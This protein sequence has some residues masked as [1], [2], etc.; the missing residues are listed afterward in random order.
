MRP[1]IQDQLAKAVGTSSGNFID[2]LFDAS[3]EPDTLGSILSESTGWIEG[4]DE[5]TRTLCLAAR[6]P[7]TPK[8]IAER[9]ING[10]EPL[11]WVHLHS[12][13][14]TGKIPEEARSDMSTLLLTCDIAS[15]YTTSSDVAP[16]AVAFAATHAGEL[17]QEIVEKVRRE[18][19]QL[20]K[21]TNSLADRPRAMKLGEMI[22][23]AALYLYRGAATS[24]NP[25][26]L[27]G[28]LWL[29]LVQIS[30]TCADLCR[31]MVDR[32]V[33]ALPSADSRHLWKLQ[34]YLRCVNTTA[35]NRTSTGMTK[36]M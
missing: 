22:L 29:E 17:G 21:D 16:L 7:D 27:I 5:D 13:V 9:L 14:K 24:E 33:E 15:L 8:Q 35:E 1:E 6:H 10:G 32:L 18:L 26:Q 31:G 19:L 34:V 4:L 36:A 3:H 30:P 25:F 11:L 12:L 20:A 28:D 23:S 2:L